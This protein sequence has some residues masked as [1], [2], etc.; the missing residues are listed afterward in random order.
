MAERKMACIEKPKVRDFLC[1][2][3][4]QAMSNR[5]HMSVEVFQIELL[6]EGHPRIRAADFR[7]PLV[8]RLLGTERY[9]DSECILEVSFRPDGADPQESG[10][11]CRWRGLKQ[12]FDQCVRTYQAP[13][14]TEF[15]ALGVAC[16][17][18]QFRLRKEITEVT[19]R[20]QK[21]DYWIG[22]RELVLEVS[23]QGEGNL[24]VLREEKAEQLR[25]NPFEKDGY[26]CVVNFSDRQANYYYYEYGTE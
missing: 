12:D 17:L 5:R 26:V 14:I 10:P 18:T 6:H 20:G 3:S 23:G 7:S 8:R 11:M 19:R 4:L 21:V 2:S 1:T 25:S 24:D 22:E 13:V 9:T 16:L 15:A